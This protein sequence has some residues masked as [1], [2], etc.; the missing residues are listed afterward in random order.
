MGVT[1]YKCFRFLWQDIKLK[2]GGQVHLQHKCNVYAKR[3]PFPPAPKNTNLS[4]KP[5]NVVR[6]RNTSK[7]KCN[8][9]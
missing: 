9:V 1:I 6:Y 3:S 2:M 5:E 8:L 4:S 7:S